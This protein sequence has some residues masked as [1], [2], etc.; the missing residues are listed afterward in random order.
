M[1]MA[2]SAER[3]SA[4]L[5]AVRLFTDSG[6]ESTTMDDIAAATGVSRR[7]LFRRFGSKE[8]VLFAEHDELLVTVQRYLEASP[9][10]PL[11]AVCSAATL[12]FQA[13]VGNPELSVTRHRL[14]RAHQRLRDREI[15]MTARYQEAFSRHLAVAEADGP[16]ALRA[17]VVAAAVIAAH[18]AVLRS[19]LRL[20]RPERAD[21]S[22]DGELWHRF[23]AAMAYVRQRFDTEPP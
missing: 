14:I 2:Q 18:N 5:A 13:Y 3:R 1:A 22:R 4:M 11:A 17:E 9:D 23:D 16:H 19:W 15:A 10:E 8:D 21:L 7:S 12:V 6:Y 20:P